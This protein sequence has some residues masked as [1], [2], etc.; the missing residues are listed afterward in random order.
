L[1]QWR[2]CNGDINKVNIVSTPASS[3]VV[4]RNFAFAVWYLAAHI[5]V[6]IVLVALTMGVLR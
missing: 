4:D 1:R 2:G 5:A 3:Q 6:L